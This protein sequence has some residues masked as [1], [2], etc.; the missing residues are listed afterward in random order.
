VSKNHVAKHRSAPERRLHHLRPRLR[1]VLLLSGTAVAA[2][3]VAVSAGVLAGPATPGVTATAVAASQ[4]TSAVQRL[5]TAELRER[6]QRVS[7]SEERRP[8]AVASKARALA[9]GAGRAATHTRD[10]STADPR[11]IARSLLPQFGMDASQFSCLDSLWVGE[12]GW[13]VHADNPSSSAYGI[14]Q[15]LPGSK[16]ASAGPDWANNPATQI[17]WGLGYVKARYGSACAA[18]SFKLGHG[19]Y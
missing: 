13:D 11:T 10:L 7:R 12:S 5:D 19:W 14:P 3:G 8:V 1:G 16:M 9:G 6:E 18:E 17:K 4:P 15:A 2:T